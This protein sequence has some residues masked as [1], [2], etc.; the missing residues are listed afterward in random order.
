M[1]KQTKSGLVVGSAEFDTRVLR[2]QKGRVIGMAVFV[3]VEGREITAFEYRVIQGYL[4]GDFLAV[5]TDY[6]QVRWQQVNVQLDEV[7]NIVRATKLRKA[8]QHD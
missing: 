6:P 2:D 8:A 1:N 5:H 7:K 3:E 4:V